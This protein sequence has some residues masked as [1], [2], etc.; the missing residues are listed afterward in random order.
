MSQEVE[1]SVVIPLYNEEENVE[2]LYQSIADVMAEMGKS[3]EIL[4]VDDGSKDATLKR[5]LAVKR[6]DP[7][8]KIIKFRRNFGQTA[9]MLA[10]FDY[11]RGR[12][13]VSMDGD[14]QNDPQDI[15]R[16]LEKLEE[17]YDLVQG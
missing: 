13:V 14:L 16:L 3:Y 5:L 7:H 2:E 9:A 6:R 12:I 8:I 15:P 11:S 1:I 10:G 4:F 17:G